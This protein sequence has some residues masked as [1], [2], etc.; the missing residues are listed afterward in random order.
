MKALPVRLRPNDDLRRSLEAVIASH[1]CAA[2]FVLSGIDSLG[3]VRLRLASAATPDELAGPVEILTLAGTICA[4]GSHLHMTI[5]DAAGSVLGG[6]VAYGC[7]VR[8]TAEVLLALLPEW[9]FNRET[10]AATGYA[11]LVA[12]H[13]TT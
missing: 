7:M 5:A 6:H 1:D 13:R 12:R 2:A 4:D 9:R 10:D 11:E 3:D 8:T